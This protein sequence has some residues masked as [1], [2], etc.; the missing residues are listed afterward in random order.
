MKRKSLSAAVPLLLVAWIICMGFPA[1]AAAKALSLGFTD[2]AGNA[3]TSV[4]RGGSFCAVIGVDDAAGVAG[5]AVTLA[6]DVSS[7]DVVESDEG[8]SGYFIAS[9]DVFVPVTDTRPLPGTPSNAVPCLGN[10]Q[11]PGVV[12]LS[13]VSLAAAQG[14]GGGAS[15]G[16]HALFTVKFTAKAGA[17]PGAYPFTVSQSTILNEAAGWGSGTAPEAVPVLVGAVGAQHED[18][19]DPTKAYPVLLGD[20]GTPFTAVQQAVTVVDAYPIT[21]TAGPNGTIACSP[22]PVDS[23]G[24]ATCTV[25]PAAGYSVDAFTVDGE[26]TVLPTFQYTFETVT[27]THTAAVTFAP[28]PTVTVKATKAKANEEGGT[29]A[30]YTIARTGSTTAARKVYFTMGGSATDAD[31]AVDDS[32]SVTIPAGMKSVDVFLTV[33]DDGVYDPKE[34]AILTLSPNSTYSIGKAAGATV[35]ITDNESVVTVNASP[36][37]TKEEGAT[38]GKYTITRKGGTSAPLTVFFSMGGTAGADGS[39]YTLSDPSGAAITAGASA[40]TIPARAKAAAVTFTTRDDAEYEPAETAVMT[41]LPDVSYRIGKPASATV[42]ITDNEP[43]ITVKASPATVKEGGT[44]VGKYRLSRKG[45]TTTAITVAY[46]MSGSAASADYTLSPENEN[47]ATIPAGAKYADV[48]LAPVDDTEYKPARTAVLT[49]TPDIAYGVGTAASAT[50]TIT[51][52][53][54]EHAALAVKSL[55]AGAPSDP[56]AARDVRGYDFNGD[57][58]ADI[59]LQDPSGAIQLWYMDKETRKQQIDLEPPV[60]DACWKLAG[61]ADFNGDGK[62]D[63][64]LQ[65]RCGE[66]WSLAVRYLDG[67]AAIG[68]APLL[69]AADGEAGLAVVGVGDFNA[70][71]NPDILFQKTAGEDR[72]VEIRYLD[73]TMQIGSQAVTPDAGDAPGGGG[74]V[75]GVADFDGDGKPDILLQYDAEGCT[76]L[77]VRFMDGGAPSGTGEIAAATPLKSAS[78]WTVGEAADFTGDGKPDILWESKEGL[79]YLWH[80]DGLQQTGG[81]LTVPPAVSPAWRVMAR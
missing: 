4:P 30:K 68:E 72:P 23:G 50:I 73:G 60:G 22:N 75:A 9:S 49:I 67:A 35:T 8:D 61:A 33:T 25:S 6:Y 58:T 19:D 77:A 69:P 80:L 48:V 57:G 34:T 32:Q 10:K 46:T 7:F 71:G 24:S 45:T 17:A 27:A 1:N 2:L 31:Y 66:R 74:A 14:T 43:V 5:A 81:A 28:T 29:T 70:D 79:L 15:A 59:L 42:T 39:D 26:T 12:M 21:A 36:A 16:P 11:T 78:S 40:V 18:W 38:V 56:P 20:A 53:D 76:R 44:A 51:D 3:L 52:N 13:G 63:L 64:L 62:L 54:P 47:A 55:S 37:K 65:H 41:L